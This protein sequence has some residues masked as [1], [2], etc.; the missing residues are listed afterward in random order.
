[1]VTNLQAFTLMSTLLSVSTYD[2]RKQVELDALR[3]LIEYYLV[4]T[5]EQQ[6]IEPALVKALVA[7]GQAGFRNGDLLYTV[8]KD[9]LIRQAS[10]LR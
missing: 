2:L 5:S 7:Q 8:V 4:H 10:D 6:E 3:F 9:R 1:M